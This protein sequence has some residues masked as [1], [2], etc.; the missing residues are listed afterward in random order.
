MGVLCL[1][2]CRLL[3]TMHISCLPYLFHIVLWALLSELILFIFFFAKSSFSFSCLTISIDCFL[4][5]ALL[6]LNLLTLLL[7]MPYSIVVFSLPLLLAPS[8]TS[9]S[10]R[11]PRSSVKWAV[12][13]ISSKTMHNSHLPNLAIKTFSCFFSC[14][15]I[16]L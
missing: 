5:N 6:L 7:I 13:S 4:L 2:L 10:S 16:I 1:L 11:A 15:S 9:V 14:W 3:Y 8:Q 12:G